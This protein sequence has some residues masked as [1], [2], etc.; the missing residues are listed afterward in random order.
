[1][2]TQ[3]YGRY[4]IIGFAAVIL[5][6]AAL[7]YF[8]LR[9]ASDRRFATSI[10]S[11]PESAAADLVPLGNPIRVRIDK[12]SAGRSKLTAFAM[13]VDGNG[14]LIADLQPLEVRELETGKR[15]EEVVFS[16]LTALP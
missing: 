8:G 15:S 11:V 3:L 16:P 6:V 5:I 13:L 1:M 4:F 12:R 2:A 14:R 7:G 10:H 9:R